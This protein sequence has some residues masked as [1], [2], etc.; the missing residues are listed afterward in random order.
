[1]SDS[2]FLNRARQ[3]GD[4]LYL[5]GL[6]AYSKAGENTEALYARWVETGGDAYGDEAEGKSRLLLA[7]RGLVEDTRALLSEAP[8]K[9]HA[10]YEECVE[11][12]KQVR[13]EDAE[14]S[15]E[16]ILAGAGAVASVRERGRRLFDGWV[17]AGEQ[18][19]AGKQQDA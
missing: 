19:S 14:G 1:M 13:G 10:L 15:N 4:K 17:S 9:R 8:R 16:F 6:G 5:A 18:L 12:G 11:T 2:T 3:W 7:G